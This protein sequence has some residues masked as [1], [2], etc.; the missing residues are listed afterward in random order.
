MLEVL[1]SIF[2]IQV[3]F[4]G[5]FGFQSWSP[6]SGLNLDG[7]VFVDKTPFTKPIGWLPKPNLAKLL[8]DLTVNITLGMF[9]ISSL[10]VLSMAN[11][12]QATVSTTRSVFVYDQSALLATYGV[13]IGL[14]LI[15]LGIGLRSFIFNGVSMKTGFLSIMT[16]TRNSDFDEIARG[17]CLG[18]EG[19]MEDFK[20]V[21][22]RFGEIGRSPAARETQGD[23]HAGF[24]LV[25]R[26]VAQINRDTEYI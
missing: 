15:A 20:N 17:A 8:E 6:S 24:G 21:K 26:G 13:S 5:A 14:A 19:T 1:M 16:S 2:G 25:D 10:S 23:I 7:T 12:T 9:S 18:A 22:V 4:G 11:N 3:T